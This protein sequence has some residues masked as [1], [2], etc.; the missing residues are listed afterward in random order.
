METEKIIIKTTFL[1]EVAAFVKR[2]PQHALTT[3]A[4]TPLYAQHIALQH[5]HEQRGAVAGP[6]RWQQRHSRSIA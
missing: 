6:E 4:H 5:A 3:I 1:C 2:V